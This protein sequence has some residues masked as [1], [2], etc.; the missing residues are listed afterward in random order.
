MGTKA[1]IDTDGSARLRRKSRD[2]EAP[3]ASRCVRGGGTTDALL[4]FVR[5]G[6]SR[7]RFRLGAVDEYGVEE[8][9]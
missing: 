3:H 8:G 5:R 4:N 2:Y 9:P 6:S 7:D 1:I